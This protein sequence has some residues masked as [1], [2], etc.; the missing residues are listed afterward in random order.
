ME[1]ELAQ[2]ALFDAVYFFYYF[3]FIFHLN[4]LSLLSFAATGSALTT[5]SVDKVFYEIH[6]NKRFSHIAPLLTFIF[7]NCHFGPLV[8]FRR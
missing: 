3:L 2:Q 7:V 6:N 5:Q 4:Y 1:S 8:V